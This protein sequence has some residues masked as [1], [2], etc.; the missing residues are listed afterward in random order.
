M[1][2]SGGSWNTTPNH[3]AAPFGERLKRLREAAGLT[4]E[5]LASK[6]RLTAKAISVLE[7]GERR[8]PYPHTVRSLADALGLGDDE[9]ASLFASVP[10]RGGPTPAPPTAAPATSA[11]P[12][13]P[14]PL[15]GREQELE[16]VGDILRRRE[17][18]LLTLTGPGGVGKTRLA[19]EVATRA[20]GTFPDGAAFVALA[21]LDDADLVLTTVLR[22][23]GLRETGGRSPRETLHAYLGGREM[24]LA[25]DNFEHVM[26]AAPEVAGLLGSSPGLV[27]LITSRAPLRVRG[28]R[29]WPVPTLAVPDPSR[30]P[31]VGTVRG[32]PA[33]RLFLD[34]AREASPAFLLTRENAAS[35]AAI[36]WR[37]EGLPLALE[38]AAAHARFLGP[39]ELLSRLDRA[40][41]AGGARDLPERQR[42][43]RTTLDWSHELLSEAER[44]MF[45]RFSVFA[46]GFE[47]EA[48]EAVGGTAGGEDVLGPLGRLVEQ[49]L[50]RTE[51]GAG[52]EARYGMLEPIRQHAL[53]KL[54]ESGEKEQVL[55]RHAAY[56]DALSGRAGPELKRPDQAAWLERLA[57]EHDNLR[58]ALSWLLER[59]KPQR[60]ALIGWEVHRFWSVRGHTGEGRLWMERALAHPGGL[61][62]AAR[63]R[64][65]YVVSMLSYVRGEPGRT[66]DAVEGSIAASR[67]AGDGEVLAAALLGQG[68]A[69]LG[70]GDLG[71]AEKILGEAL[72]M[73]REQDDP[74]GAALGLVGLAQAALAR[75][76]LEGAAGSLAEAEALSR[77]AGDWFTLI[78][79]LSG[80]ALA[81]RL[82]GKEAQTSALLREGVGLAAAL[83]DAW[84]AVYGVTGLAGAAARRAKPERAARLFG[85][86]E[87]LCEKMGVHVPSLA[88]RAL[89]EGDL[90]H[91]REK[92]DVETF[93]AYWAEGREMTLEEAVVEALAEGT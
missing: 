75:G 79:A 7:R 13:P 77:A 4:Q 88:W 36:C 26:G 9:R 37:L 66:V 81:A 72:V 74:S 14:T 59:D 41:E 22:S 15:L 24:L 19:L 25:L 17:A 67:A 5:E 11:L 12:A 6:A 60:A 54:Q 47:L 46:G 91:V 3:G 16:G 18:R 73:L 58:A 29:E 42:T 10:G 33:A 78:A 83:G 63:A 84:H 23:L 53:E 93:G 20:A 38:L 30:A 21:P 82:R 55:A 92:L 52:G 8:R 70:G 87:A 1:T 89:N 51:H 45:R 50:V 68:L 40:L 48:A 85:A 27:L 32:A 2:E 56:F 28:E 86:A 43:M 35:V 62:D 57:R 39:T 31:D 76:D 80:Q 65:L 90:A 44:A 71:A 64:A 69:A 61:P 49:S 34:R